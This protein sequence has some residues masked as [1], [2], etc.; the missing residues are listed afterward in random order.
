MR[1]RRPAEALLALALALLLAAC[2]TPTPY[3]PSN[4]S[5]FG[6]SDEQLGHNRYRVT[7]VGNSATPRATVEDYLLLRSAEVTRQA[8]ADWFVFDTRDTQ[9]HTSYFT[10][11][12]PYP[13]WGGPPGFGWYWH[14]WPYDGGVDTL[15]VTRYEA[16]AEIVLLTPEEARGEPRA[17]NASDVIAHLGPKAAAAQPH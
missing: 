13:W 9:K 4:D 2:Q 14:S 16:Y 1:R 17:L 12:D 10:T 8:G 5:R 7:F 6:Y 11:F 15:A 3:Q